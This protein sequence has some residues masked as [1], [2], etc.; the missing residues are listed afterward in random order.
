MS[1][2]DFSL[3]L[4]FCAYDILSNWTI[5]NDVMEKLIVEVNKDLILCG[6][7]R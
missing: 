7:E 1:E 5:R 4:P 6:Y 3:S 2:L